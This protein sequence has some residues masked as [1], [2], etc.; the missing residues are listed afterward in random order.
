MGVSLRRDCMGNLRV[1]LT[2]QASA[3]GWTAPA[4]CALYGEGDLSP[5]VVSIVFAVLST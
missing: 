4:R 2:G 5:G 3:F 1:H